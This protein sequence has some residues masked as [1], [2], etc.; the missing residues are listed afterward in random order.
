MMLMLLLILERAGMMGPPALWTLGRRP[1]RSGG[2]SS[3]NDGDGSTT[4][5][6]RNEGTSTS[7]INCCS[8]GAI[9]NSRKSRRG[10]PANVS[11]TSRTISQTTRTSTN[12]GTVD[13]GDAETNGGARRARKTIN[14]SKNV[15]ITAGD[16]ASAG[17]DSKRTKIIDDGGGNDSW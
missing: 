2:P 12:G 5:V 14:A 8:V 17:R 4:D 3:S 7:T 16:G 13:A 9:W 15:S 6:R 1:R 10:T 11:S